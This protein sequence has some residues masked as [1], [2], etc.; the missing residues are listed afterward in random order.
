MS[1]LVTQDAAANIFDESLMG[2]VL[3][4]NY[5]TSRVWGAPTNKIEQKLPYF[6]E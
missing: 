2:Y 6:E 4:N 3:E 1:G 5:Q